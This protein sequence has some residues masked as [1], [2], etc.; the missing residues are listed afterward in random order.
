MRT[1]RALY[2]IFCG[3]ARDFLRR[4]IVPVEE[5][6]G[7]HLVVRVPLVATDSRLKTSFGGFRLGTERSCNGRG[8]GGRGRGGERGRRGR[9]EKK[10][11]KKQCNWWCAACG[12]QYDW[13]DPNRVLVTHDVADPSE[14]KVFRATPRR[15][16]ARIFCALSSSWRTSRRE[17]TPSY[18]C[19]LRVSKNRAG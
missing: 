18:R 3:E 5:Q 12:G 8:R 13:K 9:K 1:D 17:V 10:R 14:A 7:G 16:R 6:G 19:S 2:R 4:I 11:K 15:V